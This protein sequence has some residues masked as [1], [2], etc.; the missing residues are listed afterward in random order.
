MEI[1]RGL[2]IDIVASDAPLVPSGPTSNRTS[3]RSL[4]FLLAQTVV[5]LVIFAS[6]QVHLQSVRWWWSPTVVAVLRITPEQ[7]AAIERAYED[8]LPAQR[9][10]SEDVI[11]TTGRVVDLIRAAVYDDQLLHMTEKLVNAYSSQDEVQQKMRERAAHALTLEQRQKL[12]RLI[13]QKRVL[14]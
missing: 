4:T 9:H 13:A 8:S 2:P 7:S 6:T 11:D 14:E 10:A 5:V 1:G 3:L 12:I